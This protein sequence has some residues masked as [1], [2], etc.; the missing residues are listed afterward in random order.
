MLEFGS[1]NT[2]AVNAE[3]AVLDALETAYGTS[4]PDCDLLLIN[5]TVGHD[6]AALSAV[7]TRQCPGARVLAASC[8]GVVGP[9]GPEIGR[10]HV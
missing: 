2:R 8:A 1:A 10:A 5:A 3:R 7:A 4:S 6:L 9:Q